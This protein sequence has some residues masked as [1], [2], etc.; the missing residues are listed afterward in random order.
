MTDSPSMEASATGARRLGERSAEQNAL[1][2]VVL[3]PGGGQAAARVTSIDVLSDQPAAKRVAGLPAHKLNARERIS[4]SIGRMRICCMKEIWR[5][6]LQRTIHFRAVE[7]L[8]SP[9][10]LADL[11]TTTLNNRP[12]VSETAFRIGDE[13]CEVR[14][15]SLLTSEVRLHL[16]L[17][18]PGAHK[19][20]RPH[21][22]GL[23]EGD[24][25]SSPPPQNAEFTE[26]ELAIVVR[27]D[28]VGY[29]A[30]GR[31]HGTTVA[32][33]LAGLVRMQHGDDIA[34]RLI[35]SAR[36][37]P[38]AIQ[39][40]LAQGVD[41]FDLGLSL[42]H[43]GALQVVDEQPLSFSQMIARN[44]MRGLSQRFQA[45]HDEAAID[46]LA[47]ME[48]SLT[49]NARRGA[50][51]AEIEA[52]TMLATEAVEQDEEF[53]IRTRNKAVFT[54]EKLLLTSSFN[55][56]GAAPVLSYLTAWDETASF[57]DAVP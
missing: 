40:M 43:V 48:A 17:H 2:N 3:G 25:T 28:R 45:E 46:E 13:V 50:P 29:V 6:H 11:I 47:N 51:A 15:R 20:V 22:D 5:T 56:P 10:N 23:L 44:V 49:I 14:H 30:A 7:W 42:P 31:A 41:R 33:A 38:A 21:A 12:T 8:G 52:L 1:I 9:H 39:Q 18:V 34:N 24:L 26:R 16:S 36:A 55:Q 4:D 27:H 57:L 37:D 54:R 35:L 32:R 53:R 19:S